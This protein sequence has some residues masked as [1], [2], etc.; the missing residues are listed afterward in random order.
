MQRVDYEARMKRQ[1][2]EARLLEEK[3]LRAGRQCMVCRNWRKPCDTCKKQA[4]GSRN[5]SPMRH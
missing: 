1:A 3:A 5:G 4:A 2:Q